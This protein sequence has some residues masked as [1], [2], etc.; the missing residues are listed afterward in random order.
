MPAWHCTSGRHGGRLSLA[1]RALAEAL[2][3]VGKLNLRGRE[4]SVKQHS[5]GELSLHLPL[6]SI[7]FVL[8]TRR[9]IFPKN[10]YEKFDVS[11]KT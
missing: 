11:G 8:H 7:L 6:V 1:A 5:Q 2:A 9:E 3:L 4:I 10:Q